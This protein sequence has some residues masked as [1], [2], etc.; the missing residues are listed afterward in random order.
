MAT[1]KSSGAKKAEQASAVPKSAM[2]GSRVNIQRVQNVL[3]I[4]L[5]SK[6][7]DNDE[8][9]R[10]TVTQLRCVVNDINKYTDDDQCI[11]FIN[12]ITNNKACM[13]ISGSLGQQ[14]VPRVHDMSQVDSIYLLW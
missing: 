1:G 3:L 10:N 11:Q 9:C 12:T 7:D 4:W 2:P 14:I 6:I 5:D 8:N 13:I